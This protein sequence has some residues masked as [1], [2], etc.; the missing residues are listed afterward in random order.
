MGPKI[1]DTVRFFSKRFFSGWLENTQQDNE[2]WTLLII[3]LFLN[4]KILA[5]NVL[6]QQ[7]TSILTQ[8]L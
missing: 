3:H 5:N 1:G 4:M 8:E 6:Y 7:G 2:K